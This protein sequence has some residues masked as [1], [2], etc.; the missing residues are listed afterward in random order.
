MAFIA[1]KPPSAVG[2][3]PRFGT[4][5]HHHVGIAV[6]IMRMAVPIEWFE[7]AHAE[8]AENDGPSGR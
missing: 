4:A 2:D 3:E 5:D 8:T 7:V 1:Q 6:L